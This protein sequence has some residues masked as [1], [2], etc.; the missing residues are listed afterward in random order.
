VP[1]TTALRTAWDVAALE[2]LGTAVAAL[3][4]M[5][6]A[7]AVDRAAL[8]TMAETATGRWGLIRVRRA[9]PLVDPR[10]ES[11]PESRVR[12]ALIMAGLAPVPQFE[13]FSAGLLL[14][15]VDLAFPEA[16]LAVEY[17]GAH[18]FEETQIVKDDVRIARLESAGWRIIRLSAADLR[19]LD[20]VV[21][22]VRAALAA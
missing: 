9:V 22:R 14:G 12:V 8:H 18:H 10:A 3:D 20:A 19:G 4:G 1:V 16:R 7:G 2:P 21:D 17:E 15:R 13:V 5:V 6:R 11:A